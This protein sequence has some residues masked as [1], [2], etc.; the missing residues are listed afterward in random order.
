MFSWENLELTERQ[1]IEQLHQMNF[2][3]E[4]KLL[5]IHVTTLMVQNN[6]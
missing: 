1:F 4:L 2:Q 3:K 5:T 6:W